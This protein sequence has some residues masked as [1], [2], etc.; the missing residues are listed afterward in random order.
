M[1]PKLRSKSFPF[2]S[3]AKAHGVPYGH[4]L[5]IA[6]SFWHNRSPHIHKSIS[7]PLEVQTD[8]AVEVQFQKRVK[9]GEMPFDQVP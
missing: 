6:E 1:N 2:F 9:N 4:V 8:I 5:A 7:L 3:I